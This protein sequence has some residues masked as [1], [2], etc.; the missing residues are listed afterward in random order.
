ML[1]LVIAYLIGATPGALLVNRLLRALGLQAPAA[2]GAARRTLRARVT[3]AMP[4]ALILA[5]DFGKGML[6]VWLA[7][8]VATH[9][10]VGEWRWLTQPL[11]SPGMMSV[12][13]LLV[14]VAAHDV[15]AVVIGG[16]GKVATS[17]GGF[18]VLAPVPTLTAIA[19]FAVIAA[20]SRVVWPASLIA[21]WTLPLLILYRHPND[22]LVQAAAVVTAVFA[23]VLHQEDVRR[24]FSKRAAA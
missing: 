1:V 18:M 17:F 16:G 7:P 19:L 12:A 14:A 20:A 24:V 13:A 5:L 6:A 21:N 9:V 8:L 3:A 23:T 10:A 4:S 2:G 15:S 22:R 11:I